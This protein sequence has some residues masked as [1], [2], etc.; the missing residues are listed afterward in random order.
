MMKYGF[1]SGMDVLVWLFYWA[2]GQIPG[3]FG[4]PLPTWVGRFF[5]TEMSKVPF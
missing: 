1:D 2:H 5:E 4:Y 3:G